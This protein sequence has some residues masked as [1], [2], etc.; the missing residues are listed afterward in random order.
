[1]RSDREVRFVLPGVSASAVPGRALD[2]PLTHQAFADVGSGLGAGAFLVFDDRTDPI[3]VA[4]GVAR[5]LAVES[6]GQCRPCKVD[7]LGIADLLAQASR[8]V[9]PLGAHD[10]D[11][12]AGL[13]STVDTGARCALAGQQRDA[14]GSLVELFVSDLQADLDG[15]RHHEPVP[16]APIVDLRDGVAVLDP[17]QADKQPDWTH[18][19]TDSGVSPAEVVIRRS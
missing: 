7:G 10:L 19:P 13:L 5:F 14:V 17:G 18:G 12:L 16:I 15:E 4:A 3:A 11:V 6:C 8:A 1:V 9:R 2:L